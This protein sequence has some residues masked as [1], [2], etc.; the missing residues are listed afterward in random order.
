MS[1]EELYKLKEGRPISVFPH[2]ISTAL[3]KPNVNYRNT[4]LLNED[5]IIAVVMGVYPIAN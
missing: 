3:T 2:Y 1:L 5:M 4:K